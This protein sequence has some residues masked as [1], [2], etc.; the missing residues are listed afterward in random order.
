M[1]SKGLK[2]LWSPLFFMVGIVISGYA[3]AQSLPNQVYFTEDGKRLKHGGIPSTGFY[4]ESIIR[5]IHLD[6]YDMDFWNQMLDN[7]GTDRFVMARLTYGEEVFDSVAVQFKGQTSFTRAIKDG[8]EKLSFDVKLDEVIDGQDIEGYNT[9]N[10]NNGFQDPSFMKEVLYAR[11]S[12]EFLPALKGNFIRLYLNGED[13]G[14]Y[15]NIQQLNGD[16]IREWFLSND[17]I[18]WRADKPADAAPEATQTNNVEEP[19][20]GG[21]GQ[22][23][24]GTAA[25]NWLGEAESSYQQYYTL[26]DA[27]MDD[28][29]SYLIRVC[30]LLNNSP[31]ESLYDTLSPHLDID[32]TLW[33]LAQE[34]LFSDD[35]SYVHKGKMDYYLYVEMETG[36]LVPLEFDGNSAMAIRN[37]GWS[38]FL[39]EDNANYPLLNRLLAVPELRQRYIAH[40]RTILD[41]A[42]DPVK[43]NGIIDGY[44]ALIGSHIQSDPRIDFTYDQHTRV[45]NNLKRFITDRRTNV[46]AHV[47]FQAQAPVIG[48]VL[49]MVEGVAGSVPKPDQKLTVSATASHPDG[50]EKVN[51]Y[52]GEGLKG[53][54][55][56][57]EMTGDGEGAFSATIP[58]Y[59]AGSYVRYYLE[60]VAGNGVGTASFFPAGA[61]YDVFV[62]QV[63]PVVRELTGLVINEFMA[64]NDAAAGDEFGEFDDWIEIHN[65][66]GETIFLEGYHLTDNLADLFKWSFPPDSVEPGGYLVVWADDDP[67]Q[68]DLHANFKISAGGEEILLSDSSGT[69]IDMVVFGIQEA[70]VSFGRWPNGTGDF[71]SMIPT[72]GA[73]NYVEPAVSVEYSSLPQLR[74]Y[75]NPATEFIRIEY[76]GIE[77]DEVRIYNMQGQLVYRER[78]ADEIR[79]DWLPEGI[80][81]LKTGVASTLFSVQ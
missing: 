1:H 23:G 6:F 54:F 38:P 52:Y 53:N 35:D 2:L 19:P 66:S 78:F 36:R 27:E 28:P 9:F 57:L 76:Y 16:Y 25:L 32:G 13:W 18:R 67:E 59:P 14:L 39:N 64:S 74:I 31:L 5:D 22:W 46:L 24:D 30:D 37:V 45:V 7:F 42:F 62:Y 77:T 56:R 43:A 20:G 15:P 75:P 12:R 70:D 72:F 55:T 34:I 11:L 41:Q 79:I 51:L 81:I 33:F 40:A 48:D 69:I 47:E 3:A 26:K 21:G 49:S 68:G 50:I 61:A 17:G 29:W 65:I 4:D 63:E 44:E 73:E 8:S 71:N 80:Y 58:A 10:F 60:A